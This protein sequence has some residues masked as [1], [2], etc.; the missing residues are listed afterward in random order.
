MWGNSIGQAPTN[1]N[2]NNNFGFSRNSLLPHYEIIKVNGEAG[3][4]NLRMAPN[5]SIILA[6]NNEPVI[7]VAE[8]DGAG[9][10]TVTPWDIVPHQVKQPI[11]VENLAQRVSQLEEVI[12]A[13]QSNSQKST[14]KQF[15]QQQ[16]TE[17]SM[18]ATS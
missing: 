7:W 16:S 3:A 1:N 6:D 13:R 2:N 9:Y 14:K 11:D 15:K 4:R 12:N 17:Q 10:L 5:S 8:T 18:D